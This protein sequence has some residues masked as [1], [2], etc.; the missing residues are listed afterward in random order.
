MLA[1][2]TMT[3]TAVLS[4][5]IF[6][7]TIYCAADLLMWQAS[8]QLLFS[9]DSNG[10]FTSPRRVPFVSQRSLGSLHLL[11]AADCLRA[12]D[13]S[14]WFLPCLPPLCSLVKQLLCVCAS[15][16]SLI[17]MPRSLAAPHPPQLSRSGLTE[18]TWQVNPDSEWRWIEEECLLSPLSLLIYCLRLTEPAPQWW[19]A[20]PLVFYQILT[21]FA[22][23]YSFFSTWFL[24]ILPWLA[25]YIVL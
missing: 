18:Q 3:L 22:L 19:M 21:L 11:V 17:S 24:F 15:P 10:F 9:A 12:D 2:I 20:A 5:E 13:G 23:A 7:R 14:L 25:A 4:I 6:S 16:L 8:T 1:T